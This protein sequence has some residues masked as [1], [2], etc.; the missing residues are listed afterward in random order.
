MK[1]LIFLIFIVGTTY[2]N[3]QAQ[4]FIPRTIEPQLKSLELDT[5][6]E[7]LGK[8]DSIDFGKL[9]LSPPKNLKLEKPNSA[10][11]KASM[12]NQLKLNQDQ[13]YFVPNPEQIYALRILKPVGNHHMKIYE[14]DTTKN[15]TLL[16]KKF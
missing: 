14:P 8:N 7:I 15:Y 6:P 4:R 13:I 12:L 2:L 5:S 11:T 3:T 16:I 1:K 10:D 9:Y